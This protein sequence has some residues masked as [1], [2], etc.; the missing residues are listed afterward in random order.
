MLALVSMLVIIVAVI[1]EGTRVP[2]D[3]RGDLKGELFISNGFFQAVGVISFGRPLFPS[4]VGSRHHPL[5]Y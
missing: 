3:L 2:N 1:T 4:F 5:H